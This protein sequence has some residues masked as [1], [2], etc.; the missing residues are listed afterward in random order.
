MASLVQTSKYSAMNTTYT[1][2]LGY[3]VAKYVSEAYTLQEYTT[4]D[5]KISMSDELI[6]KSKYISC[7]KAKK[8]I[9]RKHI[10]KKSLL[11]QHAQF[12]IHVLKYFPVKYVQD[13]PKNV[14]NI[15]QAQQD[16]KIRPICITDLYH[17]YILNEILRQ[18]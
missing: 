5:G 16:L 18:D 12:Y 11:F 10:S 13:I 4:C 8:G 15:N 7:M 3:Y 14:C 2:E 1:A 9:G 6:L 17:E